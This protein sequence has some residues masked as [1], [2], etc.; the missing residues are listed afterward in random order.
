[1]WAWNTYTNIYNTYTNTYPIMFEYFYLL[2]PLT[3]QFFAVVR[4][5][6]MNPK[7]SGWALICSGQ[8][9]GDSG[10]GSHSKLHLQLRRISHPSGF[11][12]ITE[13]IVFKFSVLSLLTLTCQSWLFFHVWFLIFHSSRIWNLCL[14]VMVLW[15]SSWR[16]ECICKDT[17]RA[18]ID[19]SSKWVTQYSLT[20][21]QQL[22]WLTL[23]IL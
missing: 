12:V 18:S 5:A 21:Q 19:D 11:W 22:L 6:E 17:V 10:S 20:R 8:H 16:I 2:K 23:L 9:V 15:Q 14:L 4:C 1:M 13:I 7:P 3:A